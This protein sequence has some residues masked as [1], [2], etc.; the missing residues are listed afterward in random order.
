MTLTTCQSSSSTFEVVLSFL[1]RRQEKGSG[2]GGFSRRLTVPLHFTPRQ[3]AEGLLRSGDFH[4]TLSP[5]AVRMPDTQ[6]FTMEE[7]VSLQAICLA[8]FFLQS[9]VTDPRAQATPLT[10]G[11]LNT[12]RPSTTAHAH[13]ESF[14]VPATNQLSTL[15]SAS[16][17]SPTHV[18]RANISL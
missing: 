7:S 14:H 16:Q 2:K 1:I 15:C 5:G 13:A 18:F 9:V 11:V 6:I 10:Q 4:K 12:T 17:S 8:K 3:E